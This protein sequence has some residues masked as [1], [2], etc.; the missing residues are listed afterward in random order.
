MTRPSPA[1]LCLLLALALLFRLGAVAA[2]A[3]GTAAAP[4]AAAGKADES[5]RGHVFSTSLA[6]LS[7]RQGHYFEGAQSAH[8]HTFFFPVPRDGVKDGVLRVRFRA[9]G[10]LDPL[11]SLRVD[12]N[13]RPRRLES[14]A[15]KDA[16]EW[17][18]VPVG[19]ADL[20]R[21]YLKVSLRAS[22]IGTRDRCF[23]ERSLR[24][25]FVHILPETR[26]DLNLAGTPPTLRSA[27]A[28]LPNPVRI[29]LPAKP[30]P[31]TFA[32]ALEA[33]LHLHRLNRRLEWVG[34][35]ADADLV[36]DGEEA[37]G[38]RFP[39]FKPS[40]EK[41]GGAALLDRPGRS[42][43][44][45]ISDRVSPDLFA[46]LQ[47]GWVRLLKGSAYARLPEG[48]PAAFDGEAIDLAPFGLVGAQEIQRRVEWSVHLAAPGLPAHR[49]PQSLH[50]N[51][52][53]T[54]DPDERRLMLYVYLNGQLQEVR[55]V[56]VTGKP[57]SAS[58]A[59]G[60]AVQRAGANQLRLVVQRLPREGECVNSLT[61]YPF[62]ILPGSLLTTS[63]I[64]APPLR[65]ADLR[66]LYSR[67]MD[68][69]V[70][71]PLLADAGRILPLLVGVLG[72]QDFAVDRPR[73][74]ILDGAAEFAPNRPFLL[75]GK[76]REPL[77]ES[78]VRFDRGA[79]HVV[80]AK[81]RPLLAVDRL[82]GIS[83]AQ[84]A[85]HKG[86]YGLWLNPAAEGALPPAAEI[87][88]DQDN[89]AFAD[90]KGVVLTLDSHSPN[91]SKIEYPEYR[92]WLDFIERHR[93]WLIALGWTALLALLVQLYRKTRQHH[94]VRSPA[95]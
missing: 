46:S 22:L 78:A 38:Q 24:L 16:G 39:G 42:P 30:Q 34:D 32:T 66:A 81:A 37:L 94:D 44:I 91:V 56:E 11:S 26:L 20:T 55:G 75:F 85:R 51:F 77:A 83:I 74:Q 54:P 21:D 5:P 79:L 35:A 60:S 33:A 6:D 45:A 25:H 64:D 2:E 14:L 65:F 36:I 71:R 95:P 12:V 7:L 90:D 1:R 13:D 48:A 82:P 43:V 53:G 68:L 8:A 72:N 62:E 47:P 61:G 57:Q 15:G 69:V 84:I 31:A 9:S 93:F 87:V 4:E 49:R 59:L 92:S 63:E 27:W 28:T 17:L 86:Q 40:A 19:A 41:A 88:L 23:D 18:E 67:G 50:L 70:M 73:V 58:F 76:P 80:D 10:L 29:H 89:V 52:V 3:G